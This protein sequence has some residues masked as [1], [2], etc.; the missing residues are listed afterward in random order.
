V[1]AAVGV[2]VGVPGYGAIAAFAAAFGCVLLDRA[3][4][5][6]EHAFTFFTSLHTAHRLAML[7]VVLLA[8]HALLDREAEG[9]T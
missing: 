6:D 7:G 3:A 5:P 9:P 4:H 1:V 2:L 8:A